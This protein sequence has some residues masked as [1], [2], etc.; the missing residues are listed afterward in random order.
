MAVLRFVAECLLYGAVLWAFLMLL[1]H[2]EERFRR[3]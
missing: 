1:V 2:L 3:P